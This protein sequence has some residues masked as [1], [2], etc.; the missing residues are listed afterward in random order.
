MQHR[1]GRI[2]RDQNDFPIIFASRE[3]FERILRREVLSCKRIRQIN[4]TATGVKT[5]SRD[6]C[7]LVGVTAR[8]ADGAETSFPASLVVGESS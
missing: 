5:S 7:R 4:G 8:L 6:L 1:D 3:L 2:F